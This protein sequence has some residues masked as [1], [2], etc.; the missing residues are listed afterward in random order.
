[1]LEKR[2]YT[3]KR[4]PQ[5][6]H[7][8]VRPPG[9]V[10][11]IRLDSLGADYTEE[12]IKRRLSAVRSGKTIPKQAPPP[13][14]PMEHHRYKVCSG[15]V[16]QPRRKLRGF[17]LLYVRYLYLLGVRRPAAERQI[18]PFTVR[19]EV[20]RLHRYQRQFRFLLEYRIDTAPQLSMLGDALQAELDALTS[21][22]KDLYRLKR[23][24]GEVTAELTSINQTM[25]R[26]RRKLHICEEITA[27][28][29][30]IQA[31]EQLCRETR[32]E[33]QKAAQK[34]EKSKK[35]RFD[36]WM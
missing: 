17:R 26:C 34:E 23:C 9:G 28:I 32:Q 10:R 29:P 30:R 31:Q 12:A 25:R 18:I 3:V 35:R 5:I 15:S 2:G 4:G 11:F 33:E 27:D 14:V 6:Q 22:R 13:T 1:M 7:T 20:T 19:Q 8:A 24:G 21:R 36:R 16:H